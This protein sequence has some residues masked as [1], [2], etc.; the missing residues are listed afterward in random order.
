L[1]DISHPD[2]EKYIR[3]K[4]TPN[5]R[6]KRLMD[7]Y[8]RN[9]ETTNLDRNGK[10]YFKVLEKTL[11][12]DQLT[13]F[14]IS[15]IIND[16]FMNAVKN[17]DDWNLISRLNGSIVKT[18]KA[19]YLLEL[20]AKNAWESGDPGLFMYDSVNRDNMVPYIDDLKASNPCGKFL[21]Q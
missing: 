13:H 2:I 17:D 7:E 15:V 12:D 11:Q 16:E 8:H 10:K 14:N 4:S 1:L 18:V 19:K 6:N 21:P 5:S 3:Y 9:L 20:M